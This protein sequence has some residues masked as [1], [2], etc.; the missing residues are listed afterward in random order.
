MSRRHSYPN[1][2][3]KGWRLGEC[4]P[5]V[6]VWLDTYHWPTTSRP[7]LWVSLGPDISDPTIGPEDFSFTGTGAL[8]RLNVAVTKSKCAP[9]T[10]ARLRAIFD[11]F[12]KYN[13][14]QMGATLSLPE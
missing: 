12:V 11:E 1:P 8:G 4:E 5:G 9:E 13:T 10:Y 14:A 3:V 6:Q 2:P 7:G